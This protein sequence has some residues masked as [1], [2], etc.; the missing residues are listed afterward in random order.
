MNGMDTRTID[1]FVL[2]NPDLIAAKNRP[3]KDTM[4]NVCPADAVDEPG[5]VYACEG[6]G[7]CY[8]GVWIGE[9]GGID[10]AERRGEGKV[11]MVY[12][13]VGTDDE[14]HYFVCSGEFGVADDTAGV[15]HGDIFGGVGGEVDDDFVAFAHGD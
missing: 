12:R 8:G 5:G 15:E 1:V 6:E 4:L 11:V 7:F 13:R 2:E 3:C 14:T 9:G 10:S